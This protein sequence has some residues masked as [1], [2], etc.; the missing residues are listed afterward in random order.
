M[1]SIRARHPGRLR[2]LRGR[3]ARLGMEI[4]LDFA[5]Q[6]SPIT[7]GSSN[8]H[9]VQQAADGTI[10]YAENPPKRYQ[11]IFPINFDTED[12]DGCIRRCSMWSYSGQ[13]RVRIFRVDNPPTK[14]KLLGVADRHCG[15]RPS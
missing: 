11:D 2:A 3:G 14:P 10:K 9:L 1:P 6:C 12:R 8:T 15:I 7:P 4:S 13:A 5:V